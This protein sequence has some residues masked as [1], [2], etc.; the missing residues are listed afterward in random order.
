MAA[1]A[2]GGHPI[3]IQGHEVGIDTR[4]SA[5]DV[6]RTL[7]CYHR[8]LCA[9][10]VD[11]GTL[12][13]MGAALDAGGV[14]VPVVNLLSD[15]A[16]PCQALADLLTLRQLWGPA[17]LAGRSV[18]YIGDANNVCRSLAKAGVMAGLEV[19]VAAPE[20]YSLTATDL[21]ELRSLAVASGQGGRVVTTPSPVEAATGAD[22]LYTDVW[23]SMG[24]EEEAA[25]RRAAFAGFTVDD[26]LLA[27]AAGHAAVLHC[28]PAHRAEEISAAVVDGPRSVVWTQAAHRMTAMRGLFAWLVGA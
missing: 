11:H 17:G 3:Y 27:A 16:H 12:V 6:A 8:L 7:A 19:R 10:V 28:L 5:E 24:Q 1:V 22:A 4:E 21:E 14:E 15:L 26:A 13:R 23:T 25:R 2:L 20:G 18:A 9:R